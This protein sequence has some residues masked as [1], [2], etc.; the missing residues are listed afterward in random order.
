MCSMD[1][2]TMNKS[3]QDSAS[4][5]YNKDFETKSDIPNTNN[6]LNSRVPTTGKSPTDSIISNSLSSVVSSSAPASD[7]E[8]PLVSSSNTASKYNCCN[9]SEMPESKENNIV[10]SSFDFDICMDGLLPF[11]CTD[12]NLD[13]IELADPT[14][15]G[16]NCVNTVNDQGNKPVT[17]G[18]N[19]KNTNSLITSADF[20]TRNTKNEMANNFANDD[21]TIEDF[22]RCCFDPSHLPE[23]DHDFL[24]ET[25][26]TNN[27]NEDISSTPLN[28]SNKFYMNQ[29]ET[30]VLQE[31]KSTNANLS[32]HNHHH[33][34][35]DHDHNNN[36]SHQVAFFNSDLQDS[37]IDSCGS[38]ITTSYNQTANKNINNTAEYAQ[39]L[40]YLQQQL[41]I[42]NLNNAIHC[43]RLHLHPHYEHHHNHSPYNNNNNITDGAKSNDVVTFTRNRCEFYTKQSYYECGM[44]S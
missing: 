5:S 10:C 15:T 38:D 39:P 31:N 41:H 25:P 17:D 16:N 33:T 23:I 2:I 43:N 1:N 35:H 7:S 24:S 36:H 6:N 14:N 8:F 40:S 21:E 27:T 4:Q 37:G 28:H 11:L 9:P 20:N 30:P 22:L 42:D 3:I 26:N 13:T 34:H 44:Y 32:S 18:N 19:G 12:C 29:I